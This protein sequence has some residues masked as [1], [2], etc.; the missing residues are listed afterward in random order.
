MRGLSLSDIYWY[1]MILLTY[2]LEIL[3]G[4]QAETTGHAVTCQQKGMA[5]GALS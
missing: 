3:Q 4:L 5:G 1:C 2:G